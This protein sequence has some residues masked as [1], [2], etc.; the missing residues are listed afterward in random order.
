MVQIGILH[1]LTG[2]M[3]ISEASLVDAALMAV[4]EINQQGGVLG[5]RLTPLIEDGGSNP[6]Q[7]AQKAA[8]MI[9]QGAVTIFG[10]W[11]SSSR[12]AVRP[13]VEQH[14]LLLWYPLQYEGLEQSPNIFYTGSCLNQQIEPALD[15]LLAQEHRRFFLLGSDYIFPWSAH[16]L[17]KA[18]LQAR[19]LSVVGEDYVP[20]GC[21]SFEA[22]LAKIQA[23][24]PDVIFSTLNGDSNLGFYRQY[25]Q[26]GLAA[27]D[28]PVMATSITEV[29]LQQLTGITAGHYAAWSYFQSL[30]LAS[31][32]AFVENFHRRYGSHRVTSDPIEA[33]YAQVYLWKQAVE[34][35]QSFRSD[36]VRKAAY[37][38]TF[39]A[40][41]GPI[42]LKDNHHVAKPCRIG[43]I[44]PDGQF[45]TLYDTQ[46]VIPP[47]PWLGVETCSFDRDSVVKTLLSEVSDWIE[48]NQQL[49]LE[50]AQRQQ[51]EE[52]LRLWQK[53]VEASGNA[54]LISDAQHPEMPLIY[55]NPAFETQTGY[56]AADS[57]GRN[58][59]FLQGNDHHQPALEKLRAAQGEPRDCTVVLR[60]YRK[61]GTL[62]WNELTI[63]PVFDETQQLTHFVGI[64][65]DI[66]ERIRASELLEKRIQDRTAKL[67]EALQNLQRAQC[68][69]IEKEE[70]LQYEALHDYL[71]GLPNRKHFVDQLNAFITDPSGNPRSYAV[72]F[73]DLDYFKVINDSLGHL[74][75]D[76][77][78][79]QAADRLQELLRATDLLARF[80]GDEF[81]ILLTNLPSPSYAER[82]AERIQSAITRPFHLE[83]QD[84]VVTASIG[85]TL[86]THGDRT[87]EDIL[88]DADTAMY[89]AKNQGKRRHSLFSQQMQ[90]EAMERL[91]LE[92]DLRQ[93][94][95][96]GELFLQY[97]P[98]LQLSPE[99]LSGFEALIRW[100]HP[101]LGRISPDKFISIAEETGLI[102]DIG[103]W[104]IAEACHQLSQWQQHAPAHAL[105]MNVNLSAL[106]LTNPH[107]VET[108]HEILSAT[109]LSGDQLKLELTESTIVTGSAETE[110]ILQEF[111]TLGIHICIDDFGVGH[112]SLSRLH[113]FPIDTLK[114]D[115]AFV[116]RLS[117]DRKGLEMIQII[118]ALAQSSE[119]TVVAEGIE[120]G[121]QLRQ[122][123]SLGVE[124]VQGYLFSKP[125][126]AE[127][128]CRYVQ[129]QGTKNRQP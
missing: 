47:L 28:L 119:M 88:R 66:T 67:T 78:L 60:N 95:Q 39:G 56:S 48:K 32:R 86:S 116:N 113:E 57:L 109:G 36:R 55:V 45:Q 52:K 51:A 8:G 74:K 85:I 15:W 69:L 105:T 129:A 102:H 6:D 106:Q 14:D 82:I 24:R 87:A 128:A 35:A 117:I 93:A 120:T 96:R 30:D 49:S 31:N 27:V 68:Q 122:L 37:G 65:N 124:Y 81:V 103:Q 75:G 127:A 63:S 38:Q 41:G 107:L 25:H 64:Q 123:Q 61:D 43:Q 111:R 79:K 50:I 17:I 77:L 22:I 26:A 90:L 9:A 40:P 5:Q 108:V 4:D 92:G 12:K 115:R 59:R 126:E 62:F 94:L 10:C 99:T 121:D 19:G 118:V 83:G 114:I 125:L 70:S 23:A 71:T 20:L 7:F 42:T 34:T 1:S 53:A 91:I 100:Q 84:L 16:K 97:Q 33:A 21:Q 73:L 72:L 13:V 104:V 58:C 54:I 2:E 46:T 76:L 80:G 29:E 18:H 101:T 44:Q 112:S 110:K 89:H 98:I 11:T 3:A